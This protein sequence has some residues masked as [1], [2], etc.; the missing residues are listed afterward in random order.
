MTESERLPAKKYAV[1][2]TK[3]KI[4]MKTTEKVDG[5]CNVGL[6]DKEISFPMTIIQYRIEWRRLVAASSSF[7]K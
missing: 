3:E 4:A 6:E 1:M 5:Q 7:K 2:S